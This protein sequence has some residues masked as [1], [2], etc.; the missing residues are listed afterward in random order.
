MMLSDKNI[1]NKGRSGWKHDRSYDKGVD[2]IG[3]EGDGS[4]RY[5]EWTNAFVVGGCA[6]GGGGEVGG[7]GRRTGEVSPRF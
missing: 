6:G 2:V 4:D 7:T 5:L 3:L 1:G